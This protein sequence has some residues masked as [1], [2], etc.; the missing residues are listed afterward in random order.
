MRAPKLP[1]I[2]YGGDYAP[3]QWDPKVWDVDYEIF[4]QAHIDTLTVGVFMWSLLQPDANTYDLSPL[5]EVLDRAAAEGRQICLGTATAALPPWLGTEHPEV[6][7]TDFQGRV[8]GYGQRHNACH[9]SKIYRE[10]AAALAGK[11]AERFGNHPAVIA[12]HINNEYGGFDGGCWCELCGAEF[13]IWLQKRYGTLEALNEAWNAK[14]WSHYYT[15]W[16]QIAPPNMLT[17]HWRDR[18][19]TA[20]QGITLDYRRFTTDNML[21]TYREEKEAIR[22]HSD[23]PVTTNFMGMFAHLDYHRWTE[24]LDFASW[25]NYPPDHDSASRMALAHDLMR[26]LKG[27]QTFWLMEQTPSITA[28]RQV[29]PVKRPGIMRLWSWQAIAHGADASLFFQMRQSRGACE[30]YHGA[31]ID[32]GERTDT[33]VFKEI[34]RLGADLV[35][36]GSSLVGARTRAR[37]ALLFDWDSWWALE[38]ADG[39]NR[40]VSY[41]DVL[42]DWYHALWELG[43]QVDVVP[44]TEDLTGYDLVIAPLLHMLKGDTAQRLE[45]FVARGGT[46]ITGALSGRVDE[47]AC[48]FLMDQPGPLAKILGI[49]VD[50]TDSAEPGVVNPVSLKI[51]DDDSYLSDGALVFDILS[52]DSAT[53]VGEYTSEFYAGSPAVTRNSYGEG[54]AWYIA[55]LLDRDGLQKLFEPIAKRHDL[56]GPFG[57]VPGLEYAVRVN[58]AGEEIHLLLHH[59]TEQA[60]VAAP[61]SGVDLITRREVSAGETLDLAPTDVLAILRRV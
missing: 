28:S 5:E 6:N 23:L 18:N 24:D 37:T 52:L 48:A 12:W 61:V 20:F 13:R 45:Q 27:G 50:E 21:R 49:R 17:E 46:F 53:S 3:E 15:D 36:A 39:L 1:K 47:D 56:A 57:A 60:E 14:F 8:H 44:V 11:I 29:N 9:S 4:D 32:H 19:H 10:Y 38:L 58:D 25:D 55:T 34:E 43:V 30:K 59:G 31:V 40:H 41:P 51:E 54:E 16:D 33:R 35:A 26:G 7:R 22:E 2:A 42:T